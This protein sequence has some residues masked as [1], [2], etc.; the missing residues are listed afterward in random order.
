M[1]I[2]VF[3]WFLQKAWILN[4]ASWKVGVKGQRK[5]IDGYQNVAVTQE[6]AWLEKPN[7]VKE[8]NTENNKLYSYA[9]EWGGYSQI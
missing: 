3:N 6:Q 8:P 7:I 5:R 4:I 1:T 9:N 2:N